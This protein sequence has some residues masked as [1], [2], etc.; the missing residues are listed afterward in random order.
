MNMNIAEK[1]VK[2]TSIDANATMA[3]LENRMSEKI[4]RIRERNFAMCVLFICMFHETGNRVAAESI[5]KEIERNINGIRYVYG[6]R[7]AEQII[8]Q[9][10]YWAKNSGN[11]ECL[12]Q[13]ER[14]SEKKSDQ[15][16]KQIFG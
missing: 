7:E 15:T 8:E 13:R 11:W 12:A 16:E 14:E 10:N 9:T 1:I 3:M 2:S 4:E 5:E 6:G